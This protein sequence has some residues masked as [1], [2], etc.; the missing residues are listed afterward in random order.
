MEFKIPFSKIHAFKDLSHIS[1]KTHG[2][3]EER[4]CSVCLCMYIYVNFVIEVKYF[5]T[6]HGVKPNLWQEVFKKLIKIRFFFCTIYFQPW[7]YQHIFSG[8]PLEFVSVRLA[9][10]MMV[11]ALFSSRKLPKF[12]VERKCLVKWVTSTGHLSD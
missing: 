5:S 9:V 2:L 10:N 8:A 3:G 11:L 6:K 4:S 1:V 7:K 12:I